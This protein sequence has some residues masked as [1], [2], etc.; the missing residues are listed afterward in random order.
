MKKRLLIFITCLLLLTAPV[1]LL[2]WGFCLP[3]QYEDTFLGELKYKCQRLE[4][5]EGRRIVLVGGSSLAFGVDSALLESAF[6]D[7]QVV[8]F[9]MYAALGT[10]V[11]L[12]LSTDSIRAGDIVI[13]IPEQQEQTLSDYFDGE[14]MWQALDGDFSLLSR[15]RRD[16]WDQLAGSFPAFAARK[17]GYFLSGA[18]PEPSGVYARA[19]F[20]EYGDIVSPLCSQNIMAGQYDKNTPI[21]FQSDMVSEEFLT[22]ANR[23]AATVTQKGATLWCTFCPMNALALEEGADVDGYC[24]FLREA[25]DFP[26]MGNPHHS[27]ME[28]G[29]FYDT[30]FHLNTSGKTVYTRQLIRD[31]KAMLGDSSPTDISLPDQPDPAEA[32]MTVGDSSDADCFLYEL[33][34]GQ[35]FLTGLTEAGLERSELTLPATYENHPVVG[36]AE[37]AFAGANQLHQVTVPVNITF[38]GDGA[39]QG[40]SR[41]EAL[42]LESEDPSACQVGQ[43]LLDGTNALIYVSRSALSD[44]RVNYFWSVYGNRIFSVETIL[45]LTE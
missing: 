28:S 41:L 37:S 36:V 19:S 21:R 42:I 29:W 33:R 44:Y 45:D 16:N 14:L 6:P 26:I 11:M 1:C 15:I 38:I 24:D 30:N 12:D 39:F 4:E 35:A 31:I 5:T 22:A 25:L 17:L 40:C 34:D 2:V 9:G 18:G 20:N 27:I 23:Y 13:L 8:N 43:G 3:A 7:Y 10:T 32:A